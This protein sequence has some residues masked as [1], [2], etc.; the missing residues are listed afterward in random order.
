MGFFR[1]DARGKS[2]LPNWFGERRS[3]E[4]RRRITRGFGAIS[5]A[6]G[7]RRRGRRKRVAERAAP[8]EAQTTVAATPKGGQDGKGVGCTEGTTV[9][10]EPTDKGWEKARTTRI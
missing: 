2:P 1:G 5:G 8:L 9:S 10:K 7:R 4:G 3:V 6:F